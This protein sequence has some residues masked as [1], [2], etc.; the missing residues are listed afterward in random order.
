[1]Q[2]DKRPVVEQ[3]KSGFKIAGAILVSFAAVVCFLGCKL[4]GCSVHI[5]DIFRAQRK[6][7]GP[8]C[9]WHNS[10]SVAHRNPEHKVL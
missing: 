10:V 4:L 5:P 6:A 3:V 2:M 9:D 8:D 1:M 7:V